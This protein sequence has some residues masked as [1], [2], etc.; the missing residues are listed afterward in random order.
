MS[1][2]VLI[3]RAIVA[4]NVHEEWLA[5]PDVVFY[6]S[7]RNDL[8]YRYRSTEGSFGAA[9]ERANAEAIE[10]IV[11]HRVKHER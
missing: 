6:R 1:L 8:Y 11:N 10:M 7:I 3:Y 9:A 2:G 4:E 5:D